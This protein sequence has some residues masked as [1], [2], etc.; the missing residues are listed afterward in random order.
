MGVLKF[1]NVGITS[2]TACV[3][4]AVYK[5]ERLSEI[6]PAEEVE[7]LIKAIGIVERRITDENTTSSDLCYQAARRLIDENQ[8]D[9]ESIDMLLFVSQTPDYVTPPTSS[10]LQH[11]LGLPESCGTLDMS[12]PCSGFIYALSAAFAYASNPSVNRVML[13]VGETMSKLANPRDK[14]NFPLYGDAGTVCIVEKGNFG[15]STFLLTSDGSGEKS[16]IVP[17]RGYR[18]PLNEDSLKDKEYENGNFRRLIDITMDG[19][20]T[21]N[22]AIRVIPQQVKKLMQAANIT[23]EDVDYLV[24]HQA[25]KFMI[26]FIVKRLKFD[27]NKTPFCLQKYGNTSGASVP[28]TIVSEL[29]GK[30]EG[31]KRLLLTSIGAGWCYATAYLSTCDLKILPVSEY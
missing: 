12:M 4:S 24:S 30:M 3:P 26:D 19:T 27:T 21:F 6:M 16:V 15:E 5:N 1:N 13:C 22:H 8:I 7:K 31:N 11:R 29:E 17:A 14:V 10:V 9:P 25:N 2:I 23:T 18:N 20:D 28:L